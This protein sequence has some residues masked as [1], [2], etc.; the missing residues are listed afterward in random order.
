MYVDHL[1]EEEHMRA[2][3]AQFIKEGNLV[4]NIGASYGIR[5]GLFVELGAARVI[6][7]EPQPEVAEH[8]R[9]HFK[10]RQEV[11]V[12]EAAAGPEMGTV[13]L[14]LCGDNPI[15]LATAEPAWISGIEDNYCK[16]WPMENWD[17]KI[18]ARQVTLDW[19]IDR[20]GLPDFI[21]IDVDGY[22]DQ[23]FLGLSKAPK[24]LSFEFT[25]PYLEPALKSIEMVA[26]LGLTR[27]NYIIQETM[28]FKAHRWVDA[29]SMAGIVNRLPMSSF[30]GDIFAVQEANMN[31]EKPKEE[32]KAKPAKLAKSLPKIQITDGMVVAA[33]GKGIWCIDGDK[34]RWVPDTETQIKMN[35]GMHHV[36]MLHPEQLEAIP[37][38]EPMPKVR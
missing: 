35:I 31:G 37:E 11:V 6:A 29:H 30:F 27:F 21:K 26:A 9:T 34:R 23:V 32:K 16:N 36:I 38:G 25:V 28:Q 10:D 22:E 7:L 13:E 12:V 8:L 5:T 33:P 15:P 17:K 19:L 4:F 18:T 24:A 2:M 1:D 20:Y 14:L 3:Y